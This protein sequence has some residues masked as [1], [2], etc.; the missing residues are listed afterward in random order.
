ME[1]RTRILHGR[2]SRAATNELLAGLRRGGFGPRAIGSFVVDATLRSWREA[3]TRPRAVVEATA[4]HAAVG[5]AA[6]RRG[7]PWIATSWLMAVTHLGMLEGRHALGAAN[8]LTLARAALPAAGHRL[9]STATVA[10]ALATDFADGKVARRTGSVTRFGAQGDFLAD[11]ALW[12]W[13]VMRHERSAGWR[14]ATLAAWAV[15]VVAVAAASVARGGMVDIPRSRWVRPAAAMEVLI[16]AR[17][18][19]RWVAK[20]RASGEFAGRG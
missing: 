16:G 7:L 15:P 9:G 3:R 20:R 8:V 14:L 12:T 17:V 2:D 1:R 13:F 6:G 11:T 19:I 5:I 18:L 4:V 10:A